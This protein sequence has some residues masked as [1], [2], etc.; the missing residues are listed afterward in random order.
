MISLAVNGEIYFDMPDEGE[1]FPVNG[2]VGVRLQTGNLIAINTTQTC[3][4]NVEIK[5]ML[6][7]MRTNF[8]LPTDYIGPCVYTA[9]SIQEGDGGPR[10]IQVYGNVSIAEPVQS[11]E[12][13]A[14]AGTTIPVVLDI[15]PA[16]PEV[17]FTVQ[18]NCRIPGVLPASASYNGNAASIDFPI[19]FTFYGSD[20]QFSLVNVPDNYE[21]QAPST[22]TITVLPSQ[23]KSPFGSGLYPISPSQVESFLFSLVSKFNFIQNADI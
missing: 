20:C 22:A 1:Q 14:T 15:Y 18:L 16:D 6:G 19:P 2:I 17:T 23:A 3:G 4:P 5:A 7:N 21:A 10:T 8:D 11:P 13:V 12:Q 9:T